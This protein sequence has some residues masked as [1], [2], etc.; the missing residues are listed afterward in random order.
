M[1]FINEVVKVLTSSTSV[2]LSIYLFRRVYDHYSFN[3]PRPELMGIFSD[4]QNLKDCVGFSDSLVLLQ[5]VMTRSG[6]YLDN[7]G[8]GI[9][10]EELWLWLSEVQIE[11]RYGEGYCCRML[12]P[13]HRWSTK[14][15]QNNGMSERRVYFF[16]KKRDVGLV[17]CRPIG[18]L[19]GYCEVETIE[20]RKNDKEPNWQLSTE[21][22]ER[23]PTFL[24]LVT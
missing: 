12:A 8:E 9:W 6:G 17:G 7:G 22:Y 15:G 23:R 5:Q 13:Q 19:S 18:N 4:I 2:K 21:N 20:C 1:F 11:P 16:F 14:A 3:A 10:G 24:L